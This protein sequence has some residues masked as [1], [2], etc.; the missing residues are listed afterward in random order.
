MYNFSSC[1]STNIDIVMPKKRLLADSLRSPQ[2]RTVRFSEVMATEYGIPISGD[3]V[4]VK[5]T[6]KKSRVLAKFQ[7]LMVLP[8]KEPSK[9]SH[10]A[11]CLVNGVFIHSTDKGV[12]ITALK[13]IVDEVD[14]NWI[15]IRHAEIEKSVRRD[16][17]HVSGCYRNHQ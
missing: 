15:A 14:D 4:L 3:L 7:R 8:N 5:G 13:E 9:F 11:L 12:H 16:F 1:T 6:R 17:S 2:S 10:V